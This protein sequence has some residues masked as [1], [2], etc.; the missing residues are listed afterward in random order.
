MKLLALIGAGFCVFSGLW[1]SA[2]PFIILYLGI[3][4]CQARTQVIMRESLVTLSEES[5]ELFDVLMDEFKKPQETE[6]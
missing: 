6:D 1:I 2:I 3:L 5:P 4:Y